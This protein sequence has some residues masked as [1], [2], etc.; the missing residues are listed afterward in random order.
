MRDRAPCGAAQCWFPNTLRRRAHN[1]ACLV[2]PAMLVIL[3]G[4]LA[5]RA[6]FDPLVL[7]L[8]CQ[9]LCVGLLFARL[10]NLAI[11]LRAFGRRAAARAALGGRRIALHRLALIGGLRLGCLRDRSSGKQYRAG[12]ANNECRFHGFLR[13]LYSV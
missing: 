5:F 9:L 7:V 11:G 10:N 2:P 1:H 12:E 8:T 13:W 3:A 6:L 4:L